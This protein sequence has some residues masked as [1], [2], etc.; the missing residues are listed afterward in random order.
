M[1]LVLL[2]HAGPQWDHSLPMEAQSRWDDHARCMDQLVESGVIV[3]GGPLDEVRVVLAVE[4]DSEEAVRAHLATD[5]W[6]RTHLVIDTIDAWTIRL[7]GR[8]VGR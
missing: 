8:E 5:P 7:D 6:S 2:R 1:F 3:L 4:A